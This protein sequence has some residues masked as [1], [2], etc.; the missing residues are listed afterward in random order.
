MKKTLTLLLIIFCAVGYSRAEGQ[1]IGYLNSDSLFATLDEVVSVNEKIANLQVGYENEYKLMKID[2]NK[3]VKDYIEKNATLPESI[4]LARQS[5][6]TETEKRIALYKQRYT[7]EIEHTRDSLLAPVKATFNAAI[8]QT[9]EEQHLL[10]ILDNKQALY[11]SSQC[12]NITPFVIE[13]L[14]K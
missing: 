4:K 2:Y 14:K 7:A 12:I 5:E 13:K 11:L 1:L 3:K 6:I 9:A 8:R 10:V